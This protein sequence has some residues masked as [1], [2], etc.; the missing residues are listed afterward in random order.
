MIGARSA[1][2]DA[3][4]DYLRGVGHRSIRR[5]RVPHADDGLE[6]QCE[7]GATREQATTGVA[8]TA[9]DGYRVGRD[10]S[11][12][13]G[14]TAVVV[15]TAS[16]ALG[17]IR[18]L[19]ERGIRVPLDL[20]VVSLEDTA[21]SAHFLPPLTTVAPASVGPIVRVR[22]STAPPQGTRGE[23]ARGIDHSALREGP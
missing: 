13:D 22:A 15:P 4:V 16:F 3:A 14:C 23:I 20:S 5:V 6:G 2:V 7:G 12:L 21:E 18:G 9:E 10:A 1:A 19:S 8:L 11:L 17:L